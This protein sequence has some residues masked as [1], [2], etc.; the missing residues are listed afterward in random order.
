M[1]RLVCISYSKRLRLLCC[2]VCVGA[3]LLLC[4]VTSTSL[5]SAPTT[6]RYAGF[7]S[8]WLALGS[9]I[10][11]LLLLLLLFSS[12]LSTTLQSTRRPLNRWDMCFWFKK[13]CNG[14]R[15]RIGA[16]IVPGR[17]RWL[18]RLSF[19]NDTYSA[20]GGGWSYGRGYE[21]E[22][23]PELYRPDAH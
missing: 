14:K 11:S 15:K 5:Q 7:I 2:C 1:R 10:F 13:T 19:M 18:A 21:R 17:W 16:N 23:V 20:V 12:L 6:T 3:D 22:D 9:S 4:H 8:R